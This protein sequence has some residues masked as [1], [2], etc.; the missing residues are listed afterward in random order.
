MP[1]FHQVAKVHAKANKNPR[2]YFMGKP[3]MSSKS[4]LIVQCTQ[5]KCSRHG[6]C[7]EMVGQYMWLMLDD[8]LLTKEEARHEYEGALRGQGEEEA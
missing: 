2:V 3:T 4:T 8:G 1:R 6:Q 7:Y 5:A